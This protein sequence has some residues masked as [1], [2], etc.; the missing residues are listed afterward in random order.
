MIFAFK[1]LVAST[2][3]F[4][5]VD[6]VQIDVDQVSQIVRVERFLVIVDHCPVKVEHFAPIL[7]DL[8]FRVDCV[9]QV[10][11]D[12]QEVGEDDLA[13]EAHSLVNE[14]IEAVEQGAVFVK[15]DRHKQIA[16]HVG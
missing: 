4:R 3:L 5:L 13:E 2:F 1:Q 8:V 16:D 15:T 11:D 10:L 9:R 6:L 14:E 7:G 12:R